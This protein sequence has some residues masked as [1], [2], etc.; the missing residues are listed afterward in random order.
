[1]SVDNT[2][3]ELF[4]IRE[5]IDT[6]KPSS[7]PGASDSSFSSFTPRTA[8]TSALSPSASLPADLTSFYKI[9]K[10]I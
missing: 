9:N 8:S 7:Q 6:L 2:Y 1:M 5:V 10:N 3:D 4:I